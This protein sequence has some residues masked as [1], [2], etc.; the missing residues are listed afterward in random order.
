MINK[1][2]GFSLVEVMVATALA[3]V[4]GVSGYSLYEYAKKSTDRVSDGIQMSIA[5]LGASSIL[6]RDLSSAE[7]SFNYININDD[8]GNAFFTHAK[9]QYCRHKDCS[10]ELTLEIKGS[11]TVSKPIYFIIRKSL[12]NE[13][14]KLSVH[15]RSVFNGHLY[16]GINWRHNEPTYS[17]SRDHFPITSWEE[18]RLMMVA[19]ENDFFDCNLSSKSSN[20]STCIIDCASSGQCDYSIKRPFKFLG[21]VANK[22]SIDM[23]EVR[24]D[25]SS[26]L[27][28]RNYDI[29][30]PNKVNSCA[31]KIPANLTTTK[32]FYEKLPYTPGADERTNLYYVE[33]V[34]YYLVKSDPPSKEG[35][36]L[37]R[38][39]GSYSSGNVKFEHPVK[40]MSGLTAVKFS[41]VNVSNPVIEYQFISANQR[42][43]KL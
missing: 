27:L 40:I 29:C 21:M 26:N 3:A 41:R 38:A 1:Q 35:V 8:K 22:P 12:I 5:R 36:S 16:A 31:S 28:L 6:K 11:D 25:S 14:Q 43:K 9:H 33:I 32:E 42:F 13:T 7:L 23:N 34:K 20:A 24:V 30:R 19:S 39:L 4:L 2:Q 37:V 17:L 10:R 18:K 15:P